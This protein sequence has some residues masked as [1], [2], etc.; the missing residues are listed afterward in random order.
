MALAA[1]PHEA[2][3]HLLAGQ[4]HQCISTH[5]TSLKGMSC[6]N[7]NVKGDLNS[8]DISFSPPVRKRLQFLSHNWRKKYYYK[9]ASSSVLNAT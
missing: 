4:A 5:I 7:F 6:I 1:G 3:A 2:Y 9:A 8:V